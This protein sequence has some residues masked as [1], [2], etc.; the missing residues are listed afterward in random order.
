METGMAEA[1]PGPQPAPTKK[2]GEIAVASQ[3]RLI[4]ARFRKH[5]LA[6]V[7]S[8]VLII[9]YL[10]AAFHPFGSPY[11][12]NMRNENYV[13]APPM[14]IHF[15]GLRPY[16]Y[17]LKQTLDM[18]TF[19]RTYTEDTSQRHYVRF[20]VPG[21]PYQL[22]GFIPATVR[23]FGVEEGVIFLFGTDKLGRDLFTRN[24]YA[25]AISLTIGL[26]GVVL[27][28]VLGCLFGGI[29]GYYGGIVDD[30]IQRIIEVLQSVPTIPLWMGLSAALPPQWTSLQIYF[31][32]T[33]ILS[34]IGWSGL[35]RVVRGKILE[36]RE[37]DF[38]MAAQLSGSSDAKIIGKHL[39]PGFMSYLIVD[40]TFSIPGMII[41]ETALS[42]LGLGIRPPA[43]SWGVLLQDAQNIRTISQQPWLLI[44]AGFVIVTVL[45][46]NFV[47]DGL[48][49]AAD[50]YKAM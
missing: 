1:L 37:E 34:L 13:Y 21:E 12:P 14:R 20:L 4:W 17:D 32:I 8:G 46:F 35:A 36:L 19:Q 45:M 16:V 5:K 3:W 43:V 15:D 31:G 18:Q 26:V 23:L 50:P 9:L 39:L 28:F 24:L 29:S 25:A 40:M 33:L 6:V 44:P 42:F 10:L 48:R 47:G 7:G 22:F 27:S 38:V 30:I 41:G 49:D 2:T 11:L